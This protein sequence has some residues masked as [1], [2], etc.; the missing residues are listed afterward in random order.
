M[1]SV[2]PEAIRIELGSIIRLSILC[3]MWGLADVEGDMCCSTRV[4]SA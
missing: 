1:N 2:I 3:L 4:E